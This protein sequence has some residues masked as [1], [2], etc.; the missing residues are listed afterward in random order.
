MRLSK[1]LQ[2]SALLLGSMSL[3]Q[4]TDIKEFDCGYGVVKPNMTPE[5]I[6]LACG[7]NWVPSYIS[8]H[9]RPSAKDKSKTDYFEKWMYKHT[10]SEA[11]HVLLKNGR[12]VRIFTTP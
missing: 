2:V 8:E 6:K 1:I 12:V 5:Q 10:R 7:S 11:T 4:A 3:A 9:E